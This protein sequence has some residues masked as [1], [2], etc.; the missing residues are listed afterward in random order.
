[1]SFDESL[2]LSRELRPMLPRLY[3]LS[4]RRIPGWDLTT[5]QSSAMSTLVDRG[6]LRMSELA[7]L[8]GVQLPSATSVVNGLVK[9]GLVERRADPADRRAVVIDL[10]PKGRRQVDEL[11]DRRNHSFALLLDRLDEQD[12]R[13]L[14]DA[15][16]AVAR[17]LSLGPD[18][19][20]ADQPGNRPGTDD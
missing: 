15:V 10:T 19:P 16:P 5:S 17:L 2:Q 18:T 4:R 14:E 12:R 20:E 3:H 8:E 1:M 6:P 13:L 9:L 7:A 11:V